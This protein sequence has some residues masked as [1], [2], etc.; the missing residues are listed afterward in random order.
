MTVAQDRT[1]CKAISRREALGVAMTRGQRAGRDRGEDDGPLVIWSHWVRAGI[2]ATLTPLEAKTAMV[3]AAFASRERKAFPAVSTVSRLTGSSRR[4]VLTALKTLHLRKI[5]RRGD[6]RV[7]GRHGKGPVI[8]TLQAAPIG[9]VQNT[10]DGTPIGE[11]ENTS[12]DRG[13]VQSTQRCSPLHQV[14]K[15]AS[16]LYRCSPLHLEVSEVFNEVKKEVGASGAVSLSLLEGPGNGD[17][18]PVFFRPNGREITLEEHIRDADRYGYTDRILA[19][20][21]GISVEMIQAKRHEMAKARGALTEGE[22][23]P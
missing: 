14:V 21:L 12:A 16:P 20:S 23:T 5:F 8:Y 22:A 1:E 4:A 2:L 18:R 3:L 10:S 19:R 13:E 17:G 11:A 9:E 6:D 15:P 7:K